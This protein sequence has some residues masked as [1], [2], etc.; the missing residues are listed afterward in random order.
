MTPEPPRS[1]EGPI[2]AGDRTAGAAQPSDTASALPLHAMPGHLFRRL[3]Q[4]SAALFALHAEGVDLTPVQFAALHAIGAW[5]GCDQSTIGRAIACDKATLGSV[6][7]RLQA[8]ALVAREP[9]PAD[10]RTWRLRAT[11]A[12]DGLLERLAPAIARL[13][14]DLVA[15]LSQA[16]RRELMRLL[17]KLVGPLPGPGR[18]R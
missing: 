9:D 11:P 6:L 12:G 7:D 2:A 17:H 13:Q 10:R 16:E 8:K 14:D 4:Q 15:P 1:P 5:P 18:S 3:H